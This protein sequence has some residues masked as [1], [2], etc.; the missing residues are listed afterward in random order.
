MIVSIHD[1]APSTLGPVASLLEALDGA[2]VRR[3]VLKVIPNS[4][5]RW[6]LQRSPEL[7]R[8][9]QAEAQS[10][11]EIVLHGFTHETAGR[12][13]GAPWTR[14][15][16]RLF[17]PFSGEFL[18]LDGAAMRERLN[19]GRQ[20][21]EDCGLQPGGFCAPGWLATPELDQ[22]LLECGF[23][24]RID[25][26]SVSDLRRGRR[27]L[28]PWLG[29]MGAGELQERLVGTANLLT[30][31]ASRWTPLIKVFFHPPRRS[32]SRAFER[33]LRRTAILRAKRQPL[34]YAQLLE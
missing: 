5:G 20:A 26:M 14:M 8:V 3:R 13:R 25:L 11:S 33:L 6:P 17:A 1:V 19:S 23:H 18:T 4:Q 9:L 22:A 30:W 2:G 21:L 29:Y 10:G 16:A 15:R 27:R 34:T 28:T 12:L 24:Y 32:T 31:A 7:V